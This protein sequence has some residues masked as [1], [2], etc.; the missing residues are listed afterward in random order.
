MPG[1]PY[2]PPRSSDKVGCVGTRE[3]QGEGESAMGGG[4][5]RHRGREQ[6]ARQ[7]AQAVRDARPPT[8]RARYVHLHRRNSAND[9]SHSKRCAFRP[10]R[11]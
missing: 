7:R 3:V 4:M 11:L 2:E 8:D 9:Y 1:A 6:S 5:E 10:A